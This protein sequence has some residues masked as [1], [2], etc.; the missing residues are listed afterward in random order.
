[1]WLYTLLMAVLT[2]I[3]IPAAIAAA[4]DPPAQKEEPTELLWMR[5]ALNF[6]SPK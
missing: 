6:D 5:E 3:A 2:A 4:A 1:M